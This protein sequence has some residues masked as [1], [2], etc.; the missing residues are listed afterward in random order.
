MNHYVFISVSLLKIWVCRRLKNFLKHFYGGCKFKNRSK[1]DLSKKLL[2]GNR[3][4]ANQKRENN[5][6]RLLKRGRNNIFLHNFF[7]IKLFS[8]AQ[9]LSE[10]LEF[11]P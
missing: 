3:N 10:I 7:L 6:K 11:V 1:V 2:V 8:I 4:N 9:N 5:G